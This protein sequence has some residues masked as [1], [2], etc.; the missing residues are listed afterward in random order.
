MELLA[1]KDLASLLSEQTR[2]VLPL[3]PE[4]ENAAAGL[5]TWLPKVR[6]SQMAVLAVPWQVHALAGLLV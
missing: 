2:G 5:L 4:R 6:V 3:L 1:Q